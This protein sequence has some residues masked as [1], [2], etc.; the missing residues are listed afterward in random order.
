VRNH[1]SEQSSA[2]TTD[3]VDDVDDVFSTEERLEQSNRNS[4]RF[5]G[6]PKGVSTAGDA[7]DRDEQGAR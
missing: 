3:D 5:Q 4:E 6:G 7:E 1:Q 2:S